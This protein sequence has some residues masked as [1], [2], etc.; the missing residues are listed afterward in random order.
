MPRLI[1]PI[2]VSAIALFTGAFVFSSSLGATYSTLA[3]SATS[4]GPAHSVATNTYTDPVYG[5][6][7]QYPAELRVQNVPADTGYL[8]LAERP[9]ANLGFQVFV[10]PFD[11]PAPITPQRIQ[12]ELPSVMTDKGREISIG[13]KQAIPALLFSEHDQS[14]GTTSEVWFVWPPDPQ[15]NGNY[16]YQVTTYADRANWLSAILATWR[17][18]K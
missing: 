4:P 5:F 18:E 17:F 3:T 11:E 7:F 1:F 2:I 6:S 12:Q 10:R 8:V 14:L 13:P 15:P 16:L 9:N